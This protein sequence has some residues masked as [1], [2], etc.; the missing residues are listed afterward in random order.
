M[1]LGKLIFAGLLI[2]PMLGLGALAQTPPADAAAHDQHAQASSDVMDQQSTQAL[3]D[4]I[5]ELRAKIT[6][7]ESSLMRG[8][9]AAPQSAG[10]MGMQQPSG[11][12]AGMQGANGGAGVMEME[13]MDRPMMAGMNDDVM[14]AGMPMMDQMEMMGMSRMGGGMQGGSM[15]SA[16]PGFPGASHLYHIGAA[17]FFLDHPHHIALS[18]EQQQSLAQVKEATLL[19]QA[20]MQRNIEQAEQELWVLTGADSPDAGKIEDKVRELEALKVEQRLAFIRAVGRAA[21]LLTEEQRMQLTGFMP[22]AAGMSS[23]T[24]MPDE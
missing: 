17:G 24:D 1:K 3:V 5:A 19:E 23:M 15:S 14:A 13:D 10:Q 6:Q 21:E 12:M 11:G 18:I 8:N 2:I 22:P 4:Q 7:V 16:L 9:R 20:E